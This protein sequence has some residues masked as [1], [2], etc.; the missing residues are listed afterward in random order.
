[1]QLYLT[2]TKI[3]FF[4]VQNKNGSHK[5]FILFLFCTLKELLFVILSLL[6]VRHLCATLTELRFILSSRNEIISTLHVLEFANK[7]E[8]E[9]HTNKHNFNMKGKINFISP[10]FAFYLSLSFAACLFLPSI[11]IDIRKYININIM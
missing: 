3:S 8:V 5:H 6:C 1:M 7:L 2:F 11:K 9:E 4:S 10:F